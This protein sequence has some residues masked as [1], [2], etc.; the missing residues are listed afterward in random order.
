MEQIRTDT[1]MG[2]DG[3]ITSRA[4]QVLVLTVR[5][6]EVSL[7]VSVLLGQT[8]VND[9]DLVATLANAHEEVVGLD[10]T[11][12]EGLGVDVLDSGDKLVGEQQNGLQRELA[13]AEVKEILQT[14]T[15]QVKNHSIV[16][17]LGSEPADE[18]NTDAASERLVDTS[19]ILQL[20]VL[21]L[22][23][24]ELDSNLLARNDVGTEV[25]ITERAGTDLTTDTV[26]V[27]DAKIL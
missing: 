13:V 7:G 22:N 16:V 19:L 25:N 15:Q 17:A 23:A 2:V 5:D 12:D 21:G 10:I 4:R 20:R 26:L 14:G 8:K 1:Q 3:G 6:V 11:V 18:R 9:V 27:T 24:L